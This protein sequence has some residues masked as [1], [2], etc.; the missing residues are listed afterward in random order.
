M[1]AGS[2][3]V[4]VG[5]PLIEFV[6][7]SDEYAVEM[8]LQGMDLPLVY[9]GRKVRLQFEGWPALQLVGWPSVAVGSFGGVVTAI[10]PAVGEKGMFR[11]LVTHDK[12]DIPWPDKTFLRQ[13][14]RT[15]GIVNLDEVSIGYE[16]WRQIN[17]F[18]KSMGERPDQK[19]D[20]KK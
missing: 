14:T 18:P 3:N 8:F 13:G 2:T 5:E 9:P 7:E 20:T 15:I 16:I 10:D 6:P 19:S 12:D 1:G 4:K 17:G 11:V